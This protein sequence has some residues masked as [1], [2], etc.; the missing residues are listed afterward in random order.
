MPPRV[1]TVNI[2]QPVEAEWA[3]ELRRTSIAKHQVDGP[4]RVHTLGIHGDQVADTQDHGGIYQAVYAFAREDLDVW[5]ERLG[6]H[7]PNGQF[8]E[9]ITTEG[10]DV[11]E[12]LIGERWQ[13]GT[14]VLEVASVRIPCVVFKNFMGVKGFD[15]TQWV[16]RFTQDAR[17]GPYLRVFQEGDIAAGDELTVI[18]RPDHDVTVSV[19]FKAFTTERELLPRMLEVG[20]CLDPDA[21]EVAAN[22]AADLATSPT[23]R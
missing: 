4:V 2:G 21:R 11:N 1:L 12:S 8:G 7:V 13:I 5:S 15:D 16:K 14:A 18:H 10:I 19:M 20:D 17:P 3:G 23:T 9:N 22:Y 6:R